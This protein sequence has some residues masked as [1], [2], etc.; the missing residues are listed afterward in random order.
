ML[1]ESGWARR[2]LFPF[3]HLEGWIL[4][5]ELFCRLKDFQAT[6]ILQLN[7]FGL[8]FVY[9]LLIFLFSKR[10]ACVNSYEI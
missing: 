7:A 2:I 4:A 9:I 1:E 8:M 5:E 6:Y 10:Q 3:V